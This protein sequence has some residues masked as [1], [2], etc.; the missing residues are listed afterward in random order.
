MCERIAVCMVA[1]YIYKNIWDAVIGEE[2]QCERELANEH[3]RY[4][5]VVRKDRTIIG[6][7]PRGTSWACSLFLRRGNSITCHVT[8]HRRYSANLTQGGLEVPCTLHFEGEVKDVAKLKKFM[9]SNWLN[10]NS[11][12][13]CIRVLTFSYFVMRMLY[14]NYIII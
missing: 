8:G 13:V 3:N 7:L 10:I 11:S 5:V 2:I 14:N 4:A 1:I 6:H 9:K 12:Q